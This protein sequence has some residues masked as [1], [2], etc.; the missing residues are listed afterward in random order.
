MR[1]Y[2]KGTTASPKHFYLTLIEYAMKFLAIA[3]LLTYTI[4]GIATVFLNVDPLGRYFERILCNSLSTITLF[5]V[6]TFVVLLLGSELYR[7]LITYFLIAIILLVTLNITLQNLI[8]YINESAVQRSKIRVSRLIFF[9]KAVDAFR[10][11]EVY[12]KKN[13]CMSACTQF[14]F[15][16]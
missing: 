4:G 10:A 1:I 16:L 14:V 15:Q 7:I 8:Q 13:A 12:F 5:C 11:F 6:R 9:M 3:A 2:L